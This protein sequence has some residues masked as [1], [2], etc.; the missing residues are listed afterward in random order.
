MPNIIIFQIIGLYVV[1]APQAQGRSKD[2]V[3]I[4]F[5]IEQINVISPND[6]TNISLLHDLRRRSSAAHTCVA[7]TVERAY[8]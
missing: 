8:P 2:V 5:Q 6:I 7:P 1:I 3:V 4:E